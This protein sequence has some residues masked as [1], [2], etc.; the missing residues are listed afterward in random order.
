MGAEKTSY[1][2]LNVLTYYKEIIY[3]RKK[4]K[5]ALKQEP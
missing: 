1:F 5:A 2:V 4:K 3:S